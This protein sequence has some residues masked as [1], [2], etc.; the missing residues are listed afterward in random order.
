L[1]YF[2]AFSVKVRFSTQFLSDNLCLKAT[3]IIDIMVDLD[4][5]PLSYFKIRAPKMYKQGVKIKVV[6]FHFVIKIA[7]L[8]SGITKMTLNFRYNPWFSS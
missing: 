6:K 7:R 2:I 8:Y 5:S 1:V 4:M 3:L